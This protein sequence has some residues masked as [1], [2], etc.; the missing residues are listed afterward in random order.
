MSYSLTNKLGRNPY[1]FFSLEG[2]SKLSLLISFIELY[3]LKFKSQWPAKAWW[4]IFQLKKKKNQ[5]TCS[6][7]NYIFPEN[8]VLNILHR[9]LIFKIFFY[10]S[11][12]LTCLNENKELKQGNQAEL[13]VFPDD[14]SLEWCAFCRK[15]HISCSGKNNIFCSCISTVFLCSC[16]CFPVG[17][18]ISCN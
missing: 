13:D 18:A 7:K 9:V 6:A 5:Q 11:S 4:K 8:W 16:S 12:L 14:F 2:S 3:S 15:E 17:N 1:F 10:S